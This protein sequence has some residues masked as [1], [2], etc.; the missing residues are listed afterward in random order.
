[1]IQESILDK[2]YPRILYMNVYL[3]RRGVNNVRLELECAYRSD[4]VREGREGAHLA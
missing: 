1:M 4:I 3:Q 2:A